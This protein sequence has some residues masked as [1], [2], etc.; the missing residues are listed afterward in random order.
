MNVIK[1][2]TQA[3]N[4]RIM[5]DSFKI[6]FLKKTKKKPKIFKIVKNENLF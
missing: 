3:Q 5:K 2:P 4:E 6:Y 1:C